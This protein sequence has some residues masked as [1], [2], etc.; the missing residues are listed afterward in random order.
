VIGVSIAAT[1]I[2][3]AIEGSQLKPQ[4]S[5]TPLHSSVAGGITFPARGEWA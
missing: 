5:Q 3:G 2:A 1:G 4:Q